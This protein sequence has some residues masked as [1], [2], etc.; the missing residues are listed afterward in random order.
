MQIAQFDQLI[1]LFAQGASAEDAWRSFSPMESHSTFCDHFARYVGRGYL[2]G[3]LTYDVADRA[4]NGLYLYCYHLGVDRGMPDYAFRMFNA[5]EEGEY[6]HDG[7]S[8]DTV[9]HQIY[10]RPR[11]LELVAEPD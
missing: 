5:F 8:P 4:M 2:N 10:V 3:S 9:Q 1:S 11:V 7:D 6:M